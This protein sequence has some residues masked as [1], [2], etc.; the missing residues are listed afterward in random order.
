MTAPRFRNTPAALVFIREI[1]KADAAILRYRAQEEMNRN[2][3]GRYYS[4][5]AKGRATMKRATTAAVKL[6]RAE[7]W[8][9]AAL[10]GFRREYNL[11]AKGA[12]A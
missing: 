5:T 4:E 10:D 11:G 6:S 12:A 2:C 8:K 1:T 7:A 3:A 9:A